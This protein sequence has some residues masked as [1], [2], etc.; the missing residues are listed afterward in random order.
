MQASVADQ[1]LLL[2][3]QAV[4][5]RLDG[6]SRQAR[7]LPQLKRMAA[8]DGELAAL[9]GPRATAEQQVVDL[10]RDQ[11]SAE[12]AVEQVR[13]RLDRDQHRLDSGLGS[14]KDM[15]ALSSGVR[16]ERARIGELEDAEL[17]VM[18]ALETAT[19]A[20]DALA[21]QH[22]ELA[23]LLTVEQ[24]GRDDALADI[25]D[26]VQLARVERAGVAARVPPDLLAVYDHIRG[27]SGGVGAARL[28]GARCTGCSME[29]TAAYRSRVGATPPTEIVRCEE[30]DRILVRS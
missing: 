3:L 18:E 11:R 22:A 20:R 6:L 4:D 21:G 7:T 12:E 1:Q 27:V 29:L 24:S 13:A 25:D 26:A 8:L 2:D 23:G 9:A 30:C 16:A 17:E 10:G 15:Q 5:S 19:T 14:A 28:L